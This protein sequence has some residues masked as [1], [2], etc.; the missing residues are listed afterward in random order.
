MRDGPISVVVPAHDE[1]PVIGRLL[2]ALEDGRV[3][4]DEVVV[5]CDGCD[6]DT[7]AVAR[8]FP[9]VSV[10]ELPRGGKPSAL[11][12]GD[13]MCTQFPR[14]F[15]DADVV[16]TAATLHEVARTMSETIQA[17]APVCVVDTSRSSFVVRQYYAVWT[18][19]PYLSRG[20]LGSGVVGLSESGR[21]R[22]DEFPAVIGD[23]EFVRRLFSLDE[24]VASTENAFTIMAP[25]TLDALIRV[26]TRSRLGVLQLDARHGP[27]AP[28]TASGTSTGALVQLARRPRFWVPVA[29]YATIRS[30]TRARAARRFRHRDFHGWERDE[31]SRDLGDTS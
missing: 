31:T 16:V 8:G 17:G 22:F 6:D 2:R 23:D 27:A 20:L 15:V 24:R 12:A 1:A 11:N 21:S 5:A 4:G 13:R 25:R 29:I 19:L 7:A 3:E 9:G 18:R 10:L 14:F 30:V 26:K 28:D